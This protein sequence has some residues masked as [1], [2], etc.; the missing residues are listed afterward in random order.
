MK[1]VLSIHVNTSRLNVQ[2]ASYFFS[3]WYSDCFPELKHI[4]T[5]NR[6]YFQVMQYIGERKSLTE[7]RLPGLEEIVMDSAKAR[8]VYNAA[9]SSIGKESG[10]YNI[11]HQSC[12]S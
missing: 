11:L 2:H 12:F 1:H 6:M 9:R 10:C 7:D 4:V 3:N 5:D 8:A